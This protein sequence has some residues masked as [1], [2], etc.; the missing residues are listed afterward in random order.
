M[1]MLN[2]YS[3]LLLLLMSGDFMVMA[4][5]FRATNNIPVR[6]LNDEL[7]TFAWS[8]GMNNP[9]FSAMD[10]NR[11]G[12]ED[13]VFFDRSDRS[14]TTFLNNGKTGQ[15]SYTLAPQYIPVFDSCECDEWALLEDYNCD[16]LPDVFCGGLSPFRQN[17]KVYQQVIY[18]GDSVGFEL[19]YFPINVLS[20]N[21]R[22][23]YNTPTDIPAIVDEDGDGD[24]DIISSQTGSNF[25]TLHENLAMDNYGRCDTFDFIIETNCWGHFYEGNLDNSVVVADTQFCRRPGWDGVR[26]GSR[27]VGSTLLVHDFDGNGRVDAMLG[28]V[29]FSTI[30]VVFSNTDSTQTFMDSVVY[31]YPTYDSAFYQILFPGLF[32]VDLNNDGA[33]DLIGAPNA[34]LGGENVDGTLHY[35]NEGTSDSIDL[36]FGGRGIFSGESIDVGSTA[37]PTFLDHN[38]DGLP[39]LLI[40]SDN[41]TLR[42]ADTTTL[43][44]Q[45][46]LY[47]NT[48]TLQDP[49]FTLI[50]DDYLNASTLFP[51]LQSAAPVAG[52]MDNDGDEDL[53]IGQVDGRIRYFENAAPIGQ[54][55]FYVQT[56][57]GIQDDQG[58]TIDV[59]KLASP[60]LVDFDGDGDLDMF[61]GNEFGV[62][63][64]Y[65]NSGSVSSPVWTSVQ[66]T[67]GGIKVFDE[68]GSQFSGISRPRFADYD[69]DN[70][71]EL[72]LGAEDGFVYIFEDPAAGLI[73][74]I[75]PN[76]TLFGRDFGDNAAPAITNLDDSGDLTF[77]FGS[78]RGGL[79]LWNNRP[80]DTTVSS[81]FRPRTL[82]SVSIFPNPTTGM[83]SLE[84]AGYP[85]KQATIRVINAMGQTTRVQVT[86]STQAD[87]RL[88]D[89]SSGVYIILIEQGQNRWSGRLLKE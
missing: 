59:G 37:T 65:E 9:Q 43:T 62:L 8:G 26:T 40:G 5:D 34:S 57:F 79:Q 53:F 75:I 67:F 58:E 86:S 18:P 28:D 16:G 31:S 19:A 44:F 30:N 55:A 14:F 21:L 22:P 49:E 71:V 60:E 56:T 24:I 42:S 52:D 72:L 1:G 35:L 82:P 2:R 13:L 78:A 89:L 54:D 45:L 38:G 83:V 64:Y 17:I 20:S 36:R 77:V 85:G 51:P 66:D 4:Q 46:Q 33:K 25:F 11:D 63:Y 39:D 69:G 32:Y 29:S 23:I 81:M 15:I 27:H 84:W 61:I 7:K 80:E 48:G 41:T 88:Q 87:L 47:E 10:L 70:T 3:L 76:G 6:G 68:F 74:N 73:S 50:D 12:I